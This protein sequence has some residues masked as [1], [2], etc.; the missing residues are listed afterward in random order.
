[1]NKL[2]PIFLLTIIF[3]IFACSDDAS[4]HQY[5]GI[6]EG[7][8]VEVPALT[9]G[10]IIQ[11]PVNSGDTVDKNQLLAVVDSSDLLFQREQLLASL[12][13]FTIQTEIAASNLKKVNEDYT[14]VETKYKRIANL[15]KSESVTKQALDD[16]NNQL[17]NAQT[18]V[19]NARNAL[20]SLAA[21]K[22]QVEAK[23]ESVNK[24]IRDARIVAPRQGI[25]T[26]TYYEVGEAVPQFAPVVE[27]I[28]IHKME[29]KIYI[30]EELLSQVKYGQEVTVKVDGLDK[31]LKGTVIWVSPKA[32]FTPKTILT[33]NTRTSLVYAVKISIINQ[34]GILKHGMPVVITLS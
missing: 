6:L 22:K 29:V 31:S 34:E 15:Y 9:P 28:D 18:A 20:G 27:I 33:P 26:E 3:S 24:K 17:Q 2:I 21:G 5:T 30:S 12:D 13:D 23:L 4:D 11:R 10:Q 25:I 1:M 32:E 14:Y 16:I 8:E 7:I 19:S